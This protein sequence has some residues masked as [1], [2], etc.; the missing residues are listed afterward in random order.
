MASAANTSLDRASGIRGLWQA[1]D[2]FWFSPSDPTTLGFMRLVGGLLIFYVHLSYSFDLQTFFGRD[3]WLNIE[4]A[5]SLRHNLPMFS[6]GTQWDKQ[7]DLTPRT[8]E[9][10]RFYEKW[11]YLPKQSIDKGRDIFSL[12]YHLTDPVQMRIAHTVILACMFLFAIGFCSRITGVLTWIFLLFYINR[13]NVSV[14]GM[15]TMMNILAMYLIIGPSGAA[16]SVDRLIERWIASRR[17][18]SGAALEP[19]APSVSA[20]VAIRLVQ[21]NFC[22]VYGMSGLS[23]LQGGAWWSGT[24]TWL[25]MVNYEFSPLHNPVY[26]GAL[27]YISG[28]RWLWETIMMSSTMMTLILE[29]T[30]PLL[31][32]NRKL[33]WLYICGCSV[34][35]LS[36]ALFMSLVGFSSMMLVL[37]LSFVPGW[38][39]RDIFARLTAI[40]HTSNKNA[41]YP[42]PHAPVRVTALSAAGR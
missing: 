6:P 27:R 14:F 40:F 38:T 35:H 7:A 23:K 36:I 18:V 20:N 29:L 3:A 13:S 32:W 10:I 9:E 8:A 42:M 26:M 16:F 22:F 33:R 37:L 2:R 5:D 1:W 30:M 21:I 41:D 34:F 19:P 24:A 15:D 39:I 25:T 28:R 31:I 4:L 17:G 12:W 11:G